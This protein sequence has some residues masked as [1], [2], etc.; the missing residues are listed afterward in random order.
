[1]GW[2]AD[3]AEG[4]SLADYVLSLSAGSR[5]FCCGKPLQS[6]EGNGSVG[7]PSMRLGRLTCPHCGSEVAEV[8]GTCS[9]NAEECATFLG[10]HRTAA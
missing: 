9:T 4:R 10:E 8:V 1:M 3:N 5:C 7:A 6:D 2:V